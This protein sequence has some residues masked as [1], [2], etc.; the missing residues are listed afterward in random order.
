MLYSLVVS[1]LDSSTT[2]ELTERQC[3]PVSAS[4]PNVEKT[5][6]DVSVLL[7]INGYANCMINDYL[8]QDDYERR[9]LKKKR[10]HRKHKHNHDESRIKHKHKHHKKHHKKHKRRRDSEVNLEVSVP[11][12]LSPQ[13]VVEEGVIDEDDSK[14]DDK[15][16]EVRNSYFKFLIMSDFLTKNQP[17]IWAVE[18]RSKY[19]LLPGAATFI[20][21]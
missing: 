20:A 2:V 9:R 6:V 7:L 10:K 1:E 5:T 15:S 3:T 14:D 18:G 21:Y 17:R 12:T 16:R 11:P 8:L 19:T 13:T 4:R